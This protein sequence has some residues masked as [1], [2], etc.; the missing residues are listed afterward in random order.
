MNG[1]DG[2]GGCP[3]ACVRVQMSSTNTYKYCDCSGTTGL[4][5][6]IVDGVVPTIDT[7]Q[8]DTWAAQ[9]LTV[10]SVQHTRIG[11]K[12]QNLF[13]LHE[14]EL[15]IFFCPA[16]G[17]GPLVG[18][19]TINIYYAAAFPQTISS[20]GDSVGSVNLN[21]EMANCDSLIK[22]SIPLQMVHSTSIYLLEFI[23]PREFTQWVHIAEVRFSTQFL[24]TEDPINTITE[25]H[26]GKI[27]WL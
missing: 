27:A 9:L 11:F 15:Y 22:V 8:R 24:P 14:V 4:T 10:R 23:T 19:S 3:Q 25:P 26:T 18:S 12:F 7:N 1:S 13:V 2:T 5:G 21:T 20:F 6:V 17:I 16:W